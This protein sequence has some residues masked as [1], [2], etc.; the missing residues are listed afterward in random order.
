MQPGFSFRRTIFQPLE[1]PLRFAAISIPRKMK[2]ACFSGAGFGDLHADVER[3]PDG[4]SWSCRPD[5]V[6]YSFAEYAKMLE[7]YSARQTYGACIVLLFN[8]EKHFAYLHL[9]A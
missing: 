9:K 6:T 2:S 4:G 1:Q 5:A 7:A 8:C 3:A